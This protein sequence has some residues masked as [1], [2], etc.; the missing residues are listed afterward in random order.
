MNLDIFLT[1]PQLSHWALIGFALTL[2][3]AFI[4]TRRNCQRPTHRDGRA[5]SF[6]LNVV[7]IQFVGDDEPFSIESETI[8]GKID[9]CKWKDRMT[10]S[11]TGEFR[12]SLST[13]T[14]RDDVND[15]WIGKAI[16]W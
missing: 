3:L 14:R 5:S 12:L 7:V 13:A 11:A 9:R 6:P 4:D 8:D 16:Y 15:D 2:I 10:H 1:P